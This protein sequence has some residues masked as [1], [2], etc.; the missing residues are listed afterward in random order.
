MF[1]VEICILIKT[2]YK[3]KMFTRVNQLNT[4]QK[5]TYNSSDWLIYYSTLSLAVSFSIFLVVNLY[6]HTLHKYLANLC[7]TQLKT[8][9][10]EI[11]KVLVDRLTY[12]KLWMRNEPFICNASRLQ[13]TVQGHE[14]TNTYL[15]QPSVET[16]LLLCYIHTL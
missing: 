10:N 8:K 11:C 14:R 5:I 15:V 13:R 2:L 16:W 3:M 12:C 7:V 4:S 1:L 9:W 6:R